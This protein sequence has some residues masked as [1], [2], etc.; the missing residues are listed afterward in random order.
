[1]EMNDEHNVYSSFF[2]RVKTD[3]SHFS[4]QGIYIFRQ[5]FASLKRARNKRLSSN[6]IMLYTDPLPS[7]Q[8][9]DAPV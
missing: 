5:S 4:N 8:S 7:R 1:M 2:V 6:L 3:A 9:K